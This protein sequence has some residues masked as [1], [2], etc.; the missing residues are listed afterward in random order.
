[1]PRP[2]LIICWPTCLHALCLFSAR[3]RS[4]SQAAN[5][6]V[7]STNNSIMFGAGA[8][9][10]FNWNWV[11]NIRLFFF[12]WIIF[13]IKFTLGGFC[14]VYLPELYLFLKQCLQFTRVLN[15]HLSGMIV[16]C[17]FLCDLLWCSC[18]VIVHVCSRRSEGSPESHQWLLWRP[19]AQSP[20]G[21]PQSYG[22]TLPTPEP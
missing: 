17:E 2:A 11:C 12:S 13:K 8:A 15:S 6:S 18:C 7:I 9:S 14:K 4:L 10:Y 21:S 5:L 20:H 3:D 19:G 22:R 16:L 1:M